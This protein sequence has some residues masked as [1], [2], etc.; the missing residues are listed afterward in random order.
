MRASRTITDTQPYS[1]GK[2]IMRR[3]LILAVAC[4]LVVITSPA[5]FACEQC[6]E[7]GQFDPVGNQLT[8]PKCWSGFSSG[9]ATCI[10]QTNGN[11]CNTTTDSNCLGSSTGT[12]PGR[13]KN[14]L[15]YPLTAPSREAQDCGTDLSGR[16]VREVLETVLD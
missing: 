4:A 3:R 6:L 14:P 13:D 1:E 15:S 10:P 11:S 7:T 12:G 9:V 2:K 5:L 8:A 16:C